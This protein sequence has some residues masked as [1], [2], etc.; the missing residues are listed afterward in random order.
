MKPR[1]FSVS[2]SGITAISLTCLI[3]GLANAAPGTLAQ[4]PVFLQ[5]PVEP[6]IFFMTDDSGSMSRELL[7]A[8]LDSD[9]RLTD[10]SDNSTDIATLLVGITS[11]PAF[12]DNP[13][14][15]LEDTSTTYG[16]ILEEGYAVPCTTVA[17]EEWR[18]RF[19]QY[20]ALYYNPNKTY[21]P[22]PGENTDGSAR[23][24]VASAT[25]AAIDPNDSAAGTINLLT[26]SAVLT[27]VDG[28]DVH[29]YHDTDAWKTWC[30]NQSVAATDCKGWR[31]YTLEDGN[32]KI[33]WVHKQSATA[34]TNFANWF[35]YH[36]KRENVAKFAIGS[37]VDN[38]A[39]GRVGFAPLNVRTHDV[40]INTL[41][42]SHR[43]TL[44]DKIYSTVA[45]GGTPLRSRL[46][47]VGEYYKTGDLFGTDLSS[48]VFSETDGGAC[49][50]NNTIL[51]TDGYYNGSSPTV[52][53]VD[54]DNGTPY[55]D[56]WSDTL[57]DVA[58]KYYESDATT[59][60]AA[61]SAN[62]KMHTYSVAFGLKGSIDPDTVDINGDGFSWPDPGA[63][64]AARIDDLY[65]A[66][67]N[68][69]ANYLSAQDPDALIQSL[70]D[71]V[72]NITDFTQSANSVSSS[73]SRLQEND[74]LFTSQF[75]SGNWSG[76]LFGIPIDANGDIDDAG[77]WDAADVMKNQG[78]RVILTSVDNGG[79]AF[80]WANLSVAQ[81]ASLTAGHADDS[82][83]QARLSYLRG[84][85]YSD[86]FNFRERDSEL[87]DI[88]NS[89]PVHVGKP[90]LLVSDRDPYGVAGERYSAFK[91]A[92]ADR[93]PVVYVGANDGMLHGFNAET[94]KEL[95]AYVPETLFPNLHE[96]T[97]TNYTHRYFVDE[98]PAVGDA[99]FARSGSSNKDWRTVLVGGYGA[100]GRGL[101]AL[102]VTDPDK[103]T[104][105]SANAANTV[106]WEFDNNDD[107]DLGYTFSRP[108]IGLTK[109]GR[110]AAIVGN[111][112]NADS[113]IASLFVLFL[114][115]NLE[116]GTWNEGTDYI[117]ISTKVGSTTDIN[118]MSSPAAVDSDSDGYIDRVYAGDIQGNLWAF[119]LNNTDKSKWNSAYL[120]ANNDP[121][122]LFVADNAAND[123]QPITV[124]PS[125]IRHP[126]QPTIPAGK[127]NAST[128][129][130]MIY[131]GTGQLLV[132]GDLSTT[133]TQTFYGIWDKGT[134]RDKNNKQLDRDNLVP[135]RII[136]GTD[137]N[138][139][140]EARLTD[141][142][143]VPYHDSD[144]AQRFGW[145][146]DLN[147]SNATSG[148]RVIAEAR[149]LN[150]IVFFNTYIPDDDICDSEGTSWFMFVKAT[151]GAFP[152]EA[153]IN[154]NNDDEI[155]DDDNVALTDPDNSKTIDAAPSGLKTKGNYGSP[156]LN[157]NK[158]NDSLFN[159]DPDTDSGTTV[160]EA[161]LSS[162]LLGKRISWSELRL[163]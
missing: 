119:D 147:K 83:G 39:K 159:R 116:D 23:Y 127:P 43:S 51:M 128:P 123:R 50:S 58:M 109:T 90:A 53:N 154:L 52:G 57:A 60:G 91:A 92:N 102:D 157:L 44:L 98:T 25:G 18:A 138:H 108:Y 27:E 70:A 146:M 152:D 95:L 6:N 2:T 72:R 35:T 32:L 87:G 41:T 133:D 11:P 26:D 99:Y 22:W 69:R 160:L 150:D 47:S 13:D 104:E 110:W 88:V 59:S 137:A 113:G 118:G 9:A 125:I 29:A 61:P 132:N 162:S 54:G 64:K 21:P 31:Y 12:I 38:L 75:N 124:K 156:L 3:S 129:N 105:S 28:E 81:K 68:S 48:P 153:F 42:D 40:A 121:Q 149:V 73:S 106:L 134:A 10:S 71:T 130:L 100:G 66:A 142:I 45:Y 145:L 24:P 63:S 20:N 131:F 158:G 111:G 49:Q 7:T 126:Y 79:V 144:S 86:A 85:T 135:Q 151:N 82:I 139:N 15:G 115:A 155:N 16:Y 112:Y 19:Y 34:Q 122:P 76:T 80:Q 97:S 140:R 1:L 46:K 8:D 33:N 89:S 103:F 96:L 37:V 161:D 67:V 30:T 55:S 163:E 117:K 4:S 143:V 114:D 17:E 5:S 93:T 14:C 84:D 136:E 120:K 78:G 62:P 141:E 148:E 56:S 77:K 36:R 65:H 101:F 94:G 107:A 74:R